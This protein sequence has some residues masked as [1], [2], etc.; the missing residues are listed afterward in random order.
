MAFQEASS[1]LLQLTLARD[2]KC[3]HCDFKTWD[4]TQMMVHVIHGHLTTRMR[5]RMNSNLQCDFCDAHFPTF[6]ALEDHF[7]SLHL[8]ELSVATHPMPGKRLRSI[9][10]NELQHSIKSETQPTASTESLINVGGSADSLDWEQKRKGGG[11]DGKPPP[12]PPAG[13]SAVAYP[14]LL[15]HPSQPDLKEKGDSCPLCCV[16]LKGQDG[17]EHMKHQ[18]SND[19][20]RWFIFSCS[21][22]NSR[23]TDYES[24]QRHAERSHGRNDAK[25]ITLYVC[26]VCSLDF[27][28]KASVLDHVSEAHTNNGAFRCAVCDRTFGS[29]RKLHNHQRM[30]RQ[31]CR[32]Q[33]RQ[34]EFCDFS[35]FG[36]SRV[37]Q[38]HLKSKH[39]N[40]PEVIRCR[41]CDYVSMTDAGMRK[42]MTQKHRLEQIKRE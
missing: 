34:C 16:D 11:T 15:S 26:P 19:A 40:R 31:T 2:G 38:N 37:L 42:H 13:S 10:R 6:E 5:P 25:V 17:A 21:V 30:H 9:Y 23:L 36:T 41:L 18:H 28:R 7:V 8:I 12:Q 24:A 35:A 1:T 29:R 14:F 27:S 39:R 33:E 20:D 4:Q 22:C 32:S 3:C